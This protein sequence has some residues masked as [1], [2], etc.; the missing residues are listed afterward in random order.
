MK[1]KLAIFDHDMTIVDS[2][3]AI[4]TGMNILAKGKGLKPVTKEEVKKGIALLLVLLLSIGLFAAC[5]NNESERGNED[6]DIGYGYGDEL[7]DNGETTPSASI[8]FLPADT[9]MIELPGLTPVL[10]EEMYYDIQIMRHNLEMWGPIE[11]WNATFDGNM[12]GTE[13]TYADFVVQHAVD[14]ALE[15][16]ALEAMF[17]ELGESIDVGVFQAARENYLAMFEVDD[18]GFAV[19]LEENFLTENVLRYLTNINYMHEQVEDALLSEA[20]IGEDAITAF[21]EENNVLRAQHILLMTTDDEELDE[22]IR[23]EAMALYQELQGLS[24]DALFTRFE[25]MIAAYGEDPGME[26]NPTGY[27]FMPE[28]MVPEFTETTLETGMNQVAAPVRSGFGYH[29][30]LRLPVELD[31]MVMVPG[32]MPPMSFA[33]LMAGGAFDDALEISRDELDYSFTEALEQLDVTLL[34]AVAET[35]DEAM[36]PDEEIEEE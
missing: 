4:T 32:G 30:I 17:V 13:V 35:A 1:V 23:A 10:W 33:Q 31:A 6:D 26:M 22:A 18:E 12:D 21:I 29:I 3:D 28:V 5:G 19:I 8:E 7:A 24:G 36:V 2:S 34:F 16:R 11:D 9:V 27:T 15:R 25:E 14:A 20:D